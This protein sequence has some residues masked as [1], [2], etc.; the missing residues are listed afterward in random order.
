M[1]E[2]FTKHLSDTDQQY[3][4]RRKERSTTSSSPTRIGIVLGLLVLAG[5]LTIV[6]GT[7]A[8]SSPSREAGTTALVIL[9]LGAAAFL[10]IKI[11]SVGRRRG[12]ADLFEATIFRQGILEGAN[13]PIFLTGPDAVISIFNKAAETCLGYLGEEVVGKATPLIFHDHEEVVRRAAEL[14]EELGLPVEPGTEVFLAK[15]RQ[16]LI[17]ENEWSYIRKD[18]SRFPVLVSVTALRDPAGKLTGYLGIARDN[19]PRKVMADRLRA[20]ERRYKELVDN[21]LGLI[22]IHDLQGVLLTLNPAAAR[23]LGYERHELEGTN[24]KDL[25]PHAL[26]SEF[27]QY[28]ERVSN[29]PTDGGLLKLLTKSGREVVWEYRNTR[30][31]EPGNPPCILG[32][33]LD[34]TERVR[35][36]EALQQSERRFR[37]LADNIHEVFYVYDLKV[38][39]VLYVS[40]AY[41][42]VWGRSCKDLCAGPDAFIDSVHKDDQALAQ[43]C[44]QRQRAGE[45]TEVEYRVVRPDGSV[46]WV[47]D[48]S[49]AIKSRSG[50]PYRSVGIAED[51]TER[52]LVQSHQALQYALAMI[53]AEAR[54]LSDAAGRLVKSMCEHLS[55][56]VGEIWV[57]DNEIGAL[58]CIDQWRSDTSEFVHFE[59]ATHDLTFA[60]GVGL[61]GRVWASNDVMWV[62]NVTPDDRYPRQAAASLDGL[63]SALGFPMRSGSE[64]VGVMAFFSSTKLEPNE[65]FLKLMSALGSQIGQFVDRV[66]AERNLLESQVRFRMAFDHAPIGMALVAPDGRWLKVNGALCEILGYRENELLATTFQKLTHPDDMG[67]DLEYLR[68]VLTD[69]IRFHHKEKRYFHKLGHIVWAHLSVALVRDDLGAP[70]YF[71]SQI[72]D[73]TAQKELE[74][75]LKRARD[76]ALESSNLKSEFL[77]NMSHEIRTPMN[78]VIGMTELLLDTGL[79]ADQREFALA[80][81]SS[82][83]ALL[84]LINDILDFSKIEA[85]MLAFEMI[86]FD[87]H[88]AVEE[89]IESFAEQAA[90]KRIELACAIDDDVPRVLRGDPGRLRQI[91][92]NLIGNG[93]KFI[94]HG[95]VIVLVNKQTEADNH[96]VLSFSVTDT[97]IGID[98]EAQKRLFQP[99]VQA[100]GSTTRKYGGTGL[101]LAISRQLVEMM[102]G[103]IELESTPGKGSTFTF[104]ASFESAN[105]PPAQAEAGRELA[106][107]RLL[108]VDDNPTNRAILSH[109]TASWGMNVAE[110]E[111]GIEALDMLDRG[112]RQGTPYDIAIIDGMMPGMD[113]L[114]LA[115]RIKQSPVLGHISLLFLS[116]GREVS[117]SEAES[118]G[119]AACLRK[120]VRQ[121]HL[122]GCLH[123]I[124]NESASNPISVQRHEP[125]GTPSE[126]T[127]PMKRV[128]ARPLGKVLIVED[129]VTNQ[130]LFRLQVEKLG[131]EVDIARNGLE[132]LDRLGQIGYGCVLMDCQMPE[133]D[134]YAATGHIRE[135]EGNELHTPVIALTAGAMRGDREKCLAAGMDDYLTKPISQGKLSEALA[136]WMQNMTP[137]VP[138]SFVPDDPSPQVC[139]GAGEALDPATMQRFR[140]LQMGGAGSLVDELIGIF[141]EDTESRIAE[142]DAALGER[143]AASVGTLTHSLKGSS[144]SMGAKCLGSACLELEEVPAAELF[145]RGPGLLLEIKRE[146]DRAR[147]ELSANWISSAVQSNA[148]QPSGT[149]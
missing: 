39:R 79:S 1:S 33:A 15:A 85:G 40:P 72:Q 88:S 66:Q 112:V 143:D 105:G 145:E 117:S 48:R 9:A 139:N 111:S 10:A 76:A 148:G 98:K 101:G 22:C 32:H 120:P 149:G 123:S 62:S 144:Y 61:P 8:F 57:I 87:P 70:L 125:T 13:L 42:T 29:N 138:E 118:I 137:Q 100:D 99:F 93:L 103:Q 16:G 110:A 129:N 127:G 136:K 121:S 78:G 133:M 95:E 28:L 20:G 25:A 50:K 65:E 54:G 124:S 26:R 31:D 116:S 67:A 58:R 109:Q 3:Q 69:E 24:L 104:T 60:K 140:D 132:A 2:D 102:G 63:V 108:V 81:Q 41:E 73:I 14:S 90:R 97:G 77:A 18:G 91:L 68:R 142:L 96:V 59:R 122:R 46:R 53:L 114:E 74:T 131:Y 107:L 52:R 34:I 80:I 71:V 21:S 92:T 82:G 134:G 23:A 130:R 11:D 49:F 43:S 135:R 7:G 75:E 115:R 19:T 89:T 36:E 4:R 83:G 27:D 128:V 35:S 119:F 147:D 38:N 6:L 44:T 45:N 30:F 55:L 106:G 37:Q 47:R 141:L 64:F 86:D 113:G 12:D 126:I 146:F 51:I 84:T 17:D 56:D 94:K 5:C